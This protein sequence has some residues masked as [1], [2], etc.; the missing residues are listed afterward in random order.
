MDY[1]AR[2]PGCKSRLCH[3]LDAWPFSLLFTCETEI[4]IIPTYRIIVKVCSSQ[5]M[6][7]AHEYEHIVSAMRVIAITAIIVSSKHILHAWPQD[8]SNTLAHFIIAGTSYGK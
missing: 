7:K 4:V 8:P 6:H 1:G 3:F 2:L 5:Y